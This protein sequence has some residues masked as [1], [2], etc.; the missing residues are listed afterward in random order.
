MDS[1]SV[2]VKIGLLGAGTVGQSL[3]EIIHADREQIARRTGL[4]LEI[5]AVFDRSYQKKPRLIGMNA[6]ADPSI[7]LDDPEISVVI[8]LIGGVTT[9]KDLITRALSAGKS[10]VS[11]N[12]ALLASEAGPALFAL[13]ASKGVRI[14]FE[15]AVAG[16]IPVIR[17]MRMHYVSGHVRSLHG[18]LNGTCNFIITR[19]ESEGMDYAAALKLAQEKGFAEAD[20]AFDVSGK[21]AAQKLA[22]LAGLM[23]DSYVPEGALQ[24]EGIESIR[25]VDLRIAR[26]M[27]YVIR[28]LGVARRTEEGALLRVHPAMVPENHIL[29]SVKEE[30]NAV[31]LDSTTAGPALLV[32]KGAGGTPTATAVLSDLIDVAVNKQGPAIFQGSTLRICPQSSYRFYL[33]LQTKDQP[34][35]L[36]EI[37]RVLADHRIS[38]ASF[39]QEEGPEPVQLVLI[40]HHAPETAMK[41]ALEHIDALSCVVLPSVMI[42]KEDL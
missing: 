32:G 20:P 21:D 6:G 28:L 7:V 39:H 17:A 35:V 9:A 10:V 3:I 33:R 4:S 41:Q 5:K 30:R 1:L 11:A 27:G 34:G 18:I 29:A 38:I 25:S 2:P 19:M 16:A 22:I 23:F 36:A 15:A 13:A 40:T 31:F 24:V 26:R 42:R 14:G 12:K 37:A 8:E